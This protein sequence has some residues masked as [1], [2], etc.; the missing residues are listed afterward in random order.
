MINCQL[1]PGRNNL[2]ML[3]RGANGDNLNPF[4]L[5]T[6][7]A[8]NLAMQFLEVLVKMHGLNIVYI[9]RK[10]E[11]AYW[12]GLN[13]RIIDFNVSRFLDKKLTSHAKG[14]EKSKDLRNLFWVF[15][16]PYLPGV[17]FATR[18]KTAPR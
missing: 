7:E 10:P 1:L 17:I 2:L 5:P 18:I 6:E 3:T 9:D 15:S 4:R 13:L 16:A 12:D 8:I 14:F 11:H